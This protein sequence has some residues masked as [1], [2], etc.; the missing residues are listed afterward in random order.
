MNT[1]KKSPLAS[2][3][4]WVNVL[5]LLMGVINEIIPLLQDTTMTR[6]AMVLAI[7][8]II[9]RYLTNSPLMGGVQPKEL[10]G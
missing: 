5:I 9:L 8:N 3:T 4:L 10:N 2:K 6:A 1:L 7:T